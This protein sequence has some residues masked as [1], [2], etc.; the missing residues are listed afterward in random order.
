MKKKEFHVRVEIGKQLKKSTV[1]QASFNW[2]CRIKNKNVFF[3]EIQSRENISIFDYVNLIKSLPYC[4][5]EKIKDSNYYGYVHAIKKYI[6]K[7]NAKINIEHGLY[8][9]DSVSYFA[10]YNTFDSIFTFSDYRIEVLKK[11]NVNK[12]LLAIGPY[13]HYAEP[14][15]DVEDTAQLKSKL[16]RVLLYM[17]SHSTNL[18][19]GTSPFFKREVDMVQELKVK[20]LYDTVLVCVYYRDFLYHEC[21]EYYESMGFKVTT[22][23]HQLDLNFVRRLKSIISLADCTLSNRVG[24]NLG[25]CVYMKKPHMV[26]NDFDG[27]YDLDKQGGRIGFKISSVFSNYSETISEE[28]YA[29]VDK[30]WGLNNIKTKEE[31]I[32]IL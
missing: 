19:N 27:K 7:S 20:N 3:K 25:F 12:R 22:A 18:S 4:P 13:I 23:G 26:I 28:Q 30:Y 21:I 5:L 16:G 31:L 1:L 9:N 6:G 17:P 15:L 29:I 32:K 14:L 11:H 2:F 24:T 8:L 10:N